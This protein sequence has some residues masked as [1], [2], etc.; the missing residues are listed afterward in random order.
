MALPLIVFIG[1]CQAAA[2]SNVWNQFVSP[3]TRMNAEFVRAWHVPSEKDLVCIASASVIVVQVFNGRPKVVVNVED[4]RAR[5]IYFPAIFVGFLWPYS[6][7]CGHPLSVP[8]PFFPNGRYGA[9]VGDTYLNNL[10]RDEVPPSDAL[11]RY[12]DLDIVKAAR[13]DRLMELHLDRQSYRDSQTDFSFASKIETEFRDRSLFLTSSHPE[14]CLMLPLIEGVFAQLGVSKRE[15]KRAT[16]GLQRT[17]FAN[18][19]L[20][21]HPA[22][23][24]HFGLK[25]VNENSRYIYY[26]E[27]RFTFNE[28]VLR[29]MRHEAN[30]MLPAAIDAAHGAE[31]LKARELLERALSESPDSA[32]GWRT[33]AMLHRQELRFEAARDAAQLAIEIESDRSDN[34]ASLA[35]VYLAAGNFVEAERVAGQGIEV[36]DYDHRCHLLRAKAL[37]LMGRLDDALMAVERANDCLPAFKEALHEQV[38]ILTLLNRTD[39]LKGFLSS[40]LPSRFVDERTIIDSAELLERGGLRIEAIDM[41]R[42]AVRSGAAK[43]AVHEFLVA[44]LIR[45]QEWSE[46]EAT[47]RLALQLGSTV[48][49]QDLLSQ[50]LDRLGRRREAIEILNALVASNPVRS[51]L[52]SRLGHFLF[53]EGR[54][55]D[56]EVAFRKAL[57]LKREVEDIAMLADSLYAQGNRTIATEMLLAEIIEGARSGGLYWRLGNHLYREGAVSCAE[58]FYRQACALE[59][60]VEFS[61]SLELCL[62]KRGSVAVKG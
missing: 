51:D 18:L 25:F 30:E 29:Y 24:K 32:L 28:F 22:I 59:N 39:D 4:T 9:Q 42:N 37:R 31:K 8:E 38:Q 43:L 21:I 41:L 47:A 27:G 19:S 13:V 60:N 33:M 3:I 2:L 35:E 50:A 36:F 17:P 44:L 54:F 55:V 16:N 34:Y 26:Y 48:T 40:Q 45:Q 20:P 57:T 58:A 6:G 1:D 12:L 52:F 61:R 46:A 53:R 10:I 11:K 23:I 15:I 14:L 56:A 49:L 5:I 62:Q 7:N